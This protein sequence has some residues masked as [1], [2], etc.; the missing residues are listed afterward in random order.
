M[1]R[2]LTFLQSHHSFLGGRM[3]F[4]T[5]S[6][7][8]DH[9]IDPD[10]DQARFEFSGKN[11]S[12]PG[13]TRNFTIV[14]A[15]RLT[16]K[17]FLQVLEELRQKNCL[18]SD[19][20]EAVFSSP[21]PLLI[22]PYLSTQNLETLEQHNLS[23]VDFCGNGI[24]LWKGFF[25]MRSGFKNQF[26][27][28]PV[29]MKNPYMGVAVQVA[30]TLLNCNF[31]P[32]QKHICNS[33]LKKSG[34]ISLSQ[35]NK[36]LKTMED[37]SIICRRGRIICLRD[38]D[39]LLASLKKNH[40]RRKVT[41]RLYVMKSR[42]INIQ[43]IIDFLN[44][45]DIRW[46]HS[47]LSSLH[48]TQDFKEYGPLGFRVNNSGLLMSSFPFEETKLPG[49]ADY[50]FEEVTEPLAYYNTTILQNGRRLSND[51]ECYLEVNPDNEQKEKA[52]KSL[53]ARIIDR[54]Y[55]EEMRKKYSKLFGKL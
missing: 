46:C 11:P 12:A 25:M 33:I 1:K 17:K 47:P 14:E 36:A 34:Q 45:S 21:P 28:L 41:K 18:S 39:S 32:T 23:G 55:H 44:S 5:Q 29:A 7:L 13:T 40:K 15:E 49:Q 16:T 53:R 22:T 2:K 20:L 43:Q 3:V 19:S 8:F 4:K 27:S 9:E 54:G 37:D 42:D 50:V 26:K 51:L 6:P 52:I 35:V 48:Y 30:E 38:A 10:S 31:F 24:L